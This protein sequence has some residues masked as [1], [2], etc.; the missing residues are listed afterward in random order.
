MHFEDEEKEKARLS[1]TKAS[2]PKSLN[3][4]V[5]QLS[6][7]LEKLQVSIY[8]FFNSKAWH[9]ISILGKLAAVLTGRESTPPEEKRI[10][11]VFRKY[12]QWKHGRGK[13]E[14]DLE[15]LSEW[16]EQVDQSYGKLSKSRRFRLAGRIIAV[17]SLLKFNQKNS[18]GHNKQFSKIESILK[19]YNIWKNKI[20][21]QEQYDSIDP[22]DTITV[23]EIET[24]FELYELN[25]PLK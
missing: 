5:R 17:T 2:C 1:K 3:K 24:V 4:E 16:L 11:R 20:I 15:S 6:K 18:T 22:L 19:D 12:N 7:W 21:I 8:S 13:K 9:L 25:P 10:R 23:T 14:Q